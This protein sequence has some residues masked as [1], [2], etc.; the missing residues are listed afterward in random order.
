MK[1]S[2]VRNSIGKYLKVRG[3][4]RLPRRLIFVIVFF[5]AIGVI[6][7]WFIKN[8]ALN[9]QSQSADKSFCEIGSKTDAS[10]EYNCESKENTASITPTIGNINVPYNKETLSSIFTNVHTWY[11]KLAEPLTQTEINKKYDLYDIDLFDNSVDTIKKLRGAGA[12]VICYF[13][14]GTYENW[15]VDK[16]KFPSYVLGNS[17]EDWEGERWLNIKDKTVLK[18]MKSRI[19]LAKQKG[20]SGVELDNIDIYSNN[21]GFYITQQDVKNYIVELAHYAHSKGLLIAQKNA[22]ELASFFSAYLDMAV[23]EECFEY[24]FCKD[25]SF[26][27]TKSKLVVDVEYNLSLSAFCNKAKKSKIIAA[28]ACEELNGCWYLCSK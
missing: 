15:R 8:S 3:H 7:F 28:K 5:L 14:A 11:Y 20:C 23:L 2:K 10:S 19:D 18:I 13:S 26:Y 6:T 17:L 4:F 21:S 1:I 22:P 24:N 16:N 9:N 27:T 25:F 12:I